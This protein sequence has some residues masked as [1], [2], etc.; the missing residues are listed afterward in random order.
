[1]NEYR[2]VITATAVIA[3]LVAALMPFLRTEQT[4]ILFI[5]ILLI[6]FVVDICATIYILRLAYHDTRRPRS[7]LLLMIATT[8]ALTTL[9][10]AP[11]AFLVVLRALGHAALPGNLGQIITGMGL[12]LA[13]AVPMMKAGLFAMVSRDRSPASDQEVRSE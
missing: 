5:G 13:G 3:V 7:W 10:L 1:M 6:E 12:V 2:R 8:T 4:T 9:G 11:I